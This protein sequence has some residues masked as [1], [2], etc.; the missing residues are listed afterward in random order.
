[1]KDSTQVEVLA[2]G[3]NPAKDEVG[4]VVKTHDG[5]VSTLVFD[6]GKE[7]PVKV[8]DRITLAPY[9]EEGDIERN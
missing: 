4:I 2:I 9:V 3:Y 5:T 1:M 8:G 7:P 6:R